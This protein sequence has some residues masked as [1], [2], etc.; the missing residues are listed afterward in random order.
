MRFPLG[1]TMSQTSASNNYTALNLV[2]ILT[3]VLTSS[4][5]AFPT[6]VIEAQNHLH[7]LRA[8]FGQN[9][10]DVF[11]NDFLSTQLSQCICNKCN[12]K[13]LF[14]AGEEERRQAH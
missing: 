7:S 1:K 6:H 11:V 3:C 12:S 10:I 9:P 2:P 4:M 13:S 14:S 5:R 8:G